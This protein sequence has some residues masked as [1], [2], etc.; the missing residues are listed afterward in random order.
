MRLSLI[1]RITTCALFAILA[2]SAT[3]ADVVMDWNAHLEEA[4]FTAAVPVPAQPRNAAIMHLAVFDAVNGIDRRYKPYHVVEK[5]PPGARIEAAAAQAAHTALVALFPEQADRLD[6]HLEASLAGIPGSQGQ[7]HSIA[8]GRLWGQY[9]AE[10]ILEMRAD[11]GWNQPQDPFFGGFAIGQWR[12]V[13][14][15]TDPDG[16]LPA[17]F[18]QL[19]HL[20]PFIMAHPGHFRPGPPYGAPIPQ[21]LLT[22]E[23]AADVAEVQRLGRVDSVHRTEEQGKIA[24]LWQAM[25]SIDENRGAREILPPGRRLVDN[26]RLFALMNMAACDGLIIGWDSKFAHELWRP[27]HAIR[28][29]DT[30]G[31]P[32]TVADPEWT[33]LILAPRFPEYVSNHSTMTAAIMRILEQELG[34]QHTFTLRSPLMPGFTQTYARFSEAAAQVK[35]ARIWG[36]IHFRTACNVG[37]ELGVA[38][39]DYALANYLVPI[40]PRTGVTPVGPGSAGIDARRGGAMIDSN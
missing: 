20:T 5:A 6:E 11:D 34:D 19:A 32:D 28:L 39:A 22:P 16:S 24:L 31:N 10:E 38:L 1:P 21:A 37:D 25:G 29:A 15:A 7:S 23:Y 9:V 8:L 13:P 40:K 26:A 14:T 30:D 33:G 12:S 18:P 36:G 4:I 2:S 17:A 35:E 3:K 27:H